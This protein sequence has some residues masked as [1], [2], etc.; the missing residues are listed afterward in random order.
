MINI[1]DYL[2]SAQ[3]NVS[4][5]INS[6]RIYHIENE[7]VNPEK[8]ISLE[9]N[10]QRI[11]V[12]IHNR[13]E[14]K[15]IANFEN[16]NDALGLSIILCYKYFE[17]IV[18]FDLDE[19]REATNLEDINKIITIIRQDCKEEY[20]K[21]LGEQDKSICMVKNEN[22]FDV[23]LKYGNE[24]KEI[25]KDASLFRASIVTRNYAKLLE[26][27]NEVFSLISNNLTSKV[28]LHKIFLEYYMF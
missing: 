2:N 15:N 1:L 10:A 12:F 6:T 25:L 26:T 7:M 11:G 3:Y 24:N 27:F 28:I 16:R 5:D 22:S 20:F 14:K 13:N 21:V 8:F 18:Q 9:G 23:Y 19:I 4:E 17:P